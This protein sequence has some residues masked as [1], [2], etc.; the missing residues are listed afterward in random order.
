MQR[1]QQRGIMLAPLKRQETEWFT[2][3]TERELDLMAEMGMLNDMPQE[4]RD[5]GG[6]Y[7]TIYENPLSRARKAEQAGGFY[8]MLAGVAP[9][10]QMDP[11]NNAGCSCRAS[12]SSGRSRASPRS[13]AC[14]RRGAPATTRSSSR[15]PMRR[16]CRNSQRAGGRHAGVG[17]R[18]EP[19]QR[20]PA[21][22]PASGASA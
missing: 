1:D 13:T 8:Q 6:L 22:Q 18:Q 16:H 5:G 15:R 14:P 4:L 2:P 3:Q 10:I 19:R 17:N 12:R 21:P 9:L 11:E 7:Q 20:G